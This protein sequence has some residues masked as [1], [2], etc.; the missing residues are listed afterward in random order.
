[1]SKSISNNKG[2]QGQLKDAKVDFKRHT[3]S[4]AFH[5]GLKRERSASSRHYESWNRVK[6][7]LTTD[8]FNKRRQTHACINHCEVGH[9]FNDC[10]KAKPRLVE[11]VVDIAYYITRT[12]I[13]NCLL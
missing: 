13:T 6:I 2:Q 11:S 5:M 12:P 9:V 7:L 4:N 10:P 3:K 8:E 1:M